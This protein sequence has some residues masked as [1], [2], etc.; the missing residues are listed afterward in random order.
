MAHTAKQDAVERAQLAL[1]KR[2]R[3]TSYEAFCDLM[4]DLAQYAVSMS[5]DF[6]EEAQTSAYAASRGRVM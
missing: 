2:G 6:I 4:N 5:W 1:D 3:P